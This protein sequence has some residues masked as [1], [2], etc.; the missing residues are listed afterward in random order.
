[1]KKW[2]TFRP[3]GKHVPDSSDVNFAGQLCYNPICIHT[4]DAEVLPKLIFWRISRRFCVA[5]TRSR[6]AHTTI[7]NNQFRKDRVSVPS[8]FVVASTLLAAGG[9]P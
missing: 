8:A 4:D 1:M 9:W 2:P 5:G 7:N 3:A 6:S